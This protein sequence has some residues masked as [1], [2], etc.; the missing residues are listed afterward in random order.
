MA[1]YLII[2]PGPD[3]RKMGIEECPQKEA[4]REYLD[5]P[6]RLGMI[7]SARCVGCIV[8]PGLDEAACSLQINLQSPDS[9][10]SSYVFTGADFPQVAPDIKATIPIPDRP[11]SI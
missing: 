4:V 2:D 5:K 7:A 1:E 3:A 6:R 8:R 10:T 9:F 11:A